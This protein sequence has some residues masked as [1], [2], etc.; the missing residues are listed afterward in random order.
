MASAVRVAVRVAAA[1]IAVW[2]AA[3]VV[4]SED[5]DRYAG[6]VGRNWRELRLEPCGGAVGA[7]VGAPA[8]VYACMA[9]GKEEVREW[10]RR[11]RRCCSGSG[12]AAWCRCHAEW[13]EGDTA[14]HSV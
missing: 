4:A 7:A 5:C 8:M 12:R 1:D 14:R 9:R 13:V 3:V 11:R 6:C 2:V 10:W